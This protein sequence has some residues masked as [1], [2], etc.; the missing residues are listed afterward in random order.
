V[1]VPTLFEAAS[2][3][4][5]VVKRWLVL[6][7]GCAAGQTHRH[8]LS[9]AG[10]LSLWIASFNSFAMLVA[11]RRAS[12]R[13]SRHTVW[14]GVLS[15][16]IDYFCRALAIGLKCSSICS[17][18]TGFSNITTPSCK[19]GAEDSIDPESIITGMPSW[20]SCAIKV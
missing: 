17:S 8:T 9:P 11:I 14:Q 10:S 12:S 18:V 4:L 15:L 19:A 2:V 16:D 6:K 1:F 3:L 13:A 5:T 20:R 7:L